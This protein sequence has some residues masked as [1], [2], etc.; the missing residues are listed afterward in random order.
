M[1]SDQN[2]HQIIMLEIVIFF[3]FHE[4]VSRKNTLVGLEGTK[5]QTA[6][7]YTFKFS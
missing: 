2:K 3:F 4:N 6:L 5:N 1:E 7:V